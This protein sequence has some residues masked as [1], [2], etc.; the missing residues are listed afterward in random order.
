MQ[1]INDV[2]DGEG[3]GS[4][5]ANG[6]LKGLRNILGGPGLVAAIGLIG[7]VFLNTTSY[8]VKSLP[9]LAGI[10][11]ETQK[12]ANLEKTIQG[13][14]ERESVLASAIDGFTGDT[15]RQT[16]L[17][18]TYA[19]LAAQ[20]M[21]RQDKAVKSMAATL[22]TMPGALT[23]L[24]KTTG[25]TQLGQPKAPRGASGFIPGMAG[26]VHDIR[27]GVG[28]VSSSA[29]PVAIP[30]FA[31]GGGR[32]GTMIANTGEYIV[33]NF[34]NGGSAI[35]N[36]NMI[37][38]YGMP[39]GAKPIRG[40]GGYVP[41]FVDVNKL[42]K[43]QGRGFASLS[44]AEVDELSAL[45][46]RSAATIKSQGVKS[47]L[48]GASKISAGQKA[49]EARMF[50]S[51]GFADMLVPTRGHKSSK[52][53]KFTSPDKIKKYGTEGVIFNRRGIAN[54]AENQLSNLV[55]ID[56]VLDDS[57][58]SAAN[59]VISSIHPEFVKKIPVSERELQ[60]FMSKEGAP[61]AIA[62]LKGAFFEALIGRMVSDKNATPDGM[63]LDTVMSPAVKKL[64][65]GGMKTSARFGDFKGSVSQGNDG[66]FAEQVLKN[67]GRAAGGYIPNFAGLGAA[68]EREVAA[69]VPLG[70]IRVGR[71]SKLSSPN[72]PAGLAVTNTRD[73]P[74]GLMDVVGASKGYIPNFASPADFLKGIVSSKN[75]AFN[76]VV[77]MMEQFGQELTEGKI[78]QD[79]YN[80]NVK[81]ATQKMGMNKSQMSRVNAAAGK[82]AVATEQAAA[83]AKANKGGFMSG[84]GGM[85]MMM[86]LTMGL[87]MAAGA[88]EQAGAS[89]EVTGALTG[90]GTGA[91]IGM[92]F[93][94][95]GAAVGATIGGL[96]KLAYEASKVGVSLEELEKDLSEFDKTTKETTTA[97]E[98]YVQA[99]QDMLTAGSQKELE[100]AQKNAADALERIKGT[101]LEKSFAEAGNNVES[102]T[103]SLASFVGA[104]E[105]E[106]EV[107][108]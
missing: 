92:I 50:N 80:A 31:F 13:I 43:F 33:P 16:S 78:N 2:I 18:A 1:G 3:A 107:D 47:T 23:A 35:F 72:N 87:P 75:P 42:A 67:R 19:E 51:T 101:Q 36:P 63:T 84:A 98:A 39:A 89:R 30:N 8:I 26:E 83:T 32:R 57:I 79:Q 90:A 68:V 53:L 49:Q 62:A 64:F 96:G 82:F 17:I 48:A 15:A 10:T 99:Q 60:P 22:R 59:T 9:A 4:E 102:L 71:S 70:S 91:S 108:V 38:Q 94:P 54:N 93:G 100:K 73:E 44:S 81:A 46:G 56:E 76:K 21:E 25:G 66:K 58:V 12:R 37:A 55:R 95:M 52:V 28:G 85:G 86:G 7:K 20:D 45:T 41:N 61:G 27:R 40:A 14:M 106:R 97:G 103:D 6:L 5:I 11:T 74:R 24:S 69:G 104:Q 34:S 65:V 77:K 88:L 29:R 105:A